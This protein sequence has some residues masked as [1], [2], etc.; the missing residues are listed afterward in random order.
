LKKKIL[1]FIRLIIINKLL[2]SQYRETEFHVDAG[3]KGFKLIYKSKKN[4]IPDQ[5]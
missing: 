4:D 5:R 3:V 1:E 2:K